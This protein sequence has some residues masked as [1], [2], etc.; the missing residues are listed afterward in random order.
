VLE[1]ILY[2]CW[3]ILVHITR[4]SQQASNALVVKTWGQMSPNVPMSILLNCYLKDTD[5]T[6][7]LHPMPERC[8]NIAVAGNRGN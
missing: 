3:C 4:I 8:R 5:K 7:S 6:K 2:C 1:Y